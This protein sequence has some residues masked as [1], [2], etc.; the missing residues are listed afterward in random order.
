M[1]V[2]VFHQY[3]EKVDLSGLISI[4][5]DGSQDRNLGAA[6]FNVLMKDGNIKFTV[7][8][9]I[10]NVDMI[11]FF[12]SNSSFSQFVSPPLSLQAPNAEA[13]ELWKGYIRSVAEVCAVLTF[14][15]TISFFIF[16]KCLK[17]N[18]DWCLDIVNIRPLRV[19]LQ[20]SV[21]SSLNLLPGQIH[22]LREAVER[23]KQRMNNVPPPAASNSSPYII[24]Q[25][26]MPA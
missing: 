16:K 10:E 26:D 2:C 12:Q 15:S 6:R 20:L 21:P 8:E 11:L 24:L 9:Y 7:R 14:S 23:E 25:A 22:M 4:T 19:S 3:T 17:V 18:R 5:D 1:C 13:R